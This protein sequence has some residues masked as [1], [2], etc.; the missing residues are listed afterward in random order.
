MTLM[1][2]FDPYAELGNYKACDIPKEDRKNHAG[3]YVARTMNG[4]Q[5]LVYGETIREL[6]ESLRMQYEGLYKDN[7]VVIDK[8]ARD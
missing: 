4:E 1:S 6:L 5:I 2:E 3:D 7:E 8:N